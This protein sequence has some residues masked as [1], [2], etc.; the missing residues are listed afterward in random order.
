MGDFGLP[1]NTI[2]RPC[3]DGFSGKISLN[4]QTP[5]GGGGE[6]QLSLLKKLNFLNRINV[7][8]YNNADGQTNGDKFD[9]GKAKLCV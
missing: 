4:D 9:T 3:S 7:Y 5:L 6:L 8:K 2:S 1:F